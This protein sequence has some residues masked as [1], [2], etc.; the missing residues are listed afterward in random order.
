[1]RERWLVVVVER[2]EVV[3]SRELVGCSGWAERDVGGE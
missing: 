2:R 1:M 3:G